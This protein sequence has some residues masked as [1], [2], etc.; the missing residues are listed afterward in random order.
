MNTRNIHN[1]CLR[2]GI[3]VLAACAAA[4]WPTRAAEQVSGSIMF[5]RTELKQDTTPAN[6]TL[7]RYDVGSGTTRELTPAMKN[8]LDG[9]GSWSPDGKRI[10]F[11]RASIRDSR[12][13]SYH[14]HILDSATGRVRSL[15]SGDGSF[16]APAWGPG[17]RI[18]VAATYPERSCVTIVDAIRRTPRDLYC[19]PAPTQIQRVVWS[20][21]RR[22]LLVEA[23]YYSGGLEPTWR[24]LAY[25]VDLATGAPTVLSDL[26]MDWPLR[27]EFSPGGHRGV[28]ADVVPWDLLQVD[29]D[30]GQSRVIGWGY[31]PRWSRDGKR[32]AYTGETYELEP[33]FRYYHPLYV[34]NAD[35][36]GT[37]RITASRTPDHAYIA[38]DWS[39]DNVHVVAT[40]RT[41]ADVGLTIPRYALRIINVDNSVVVSL[42]PGSVDAGAWFEP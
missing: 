3:W 19:P 39:K 38:A 13:A 18:A 24:A 7:W 28:Y 21:D 5:M 41:Y 22:S 6:R 30:T 12:A 20:A 26:V 40:R 17:E 37:R 1:A 27:L 31:A 2:A 16:R 32:I 8:V 4:A 29:F 10:A 25:R 14:V 11:E 36:S 23:G 35:G 34:V 42:P 33:G 15:A 9:G